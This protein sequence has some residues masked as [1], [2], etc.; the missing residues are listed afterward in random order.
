MSVIKRGFLYITRKR[1]RSILLLVIMFVAAVLAMLGLAVKSSADK[2]ADAVRKSLGSSFAINQNEDM[3]SDKAHV[4]STDL[5]SQ[6]LK[7]DHITGYYADMVA[8]MI[9]VDAQLSPGQAA[10]IYKG[11]QE[12]PEYYSNPNIPFNLDQITT[13]MHIPEMC[14]C[15]NSALH[16]F[17]R[18][19]AFTLVQG[20]HIQDGD[21]NKAVISTDVAKRNNL[22]VG[23]TITLENRE[24]YCVSPLSDDYKKIV[25]EPIKLDIVGLFDVN[26][27][28]E[29]SFIGDKNGS[30]AILT[31]EPEIAENMIFSDLATGIQAKNIVQTYQKDN[32]LEERRDSRLGLNSATFFVDDPANL[33]AAIAEVKAIQEIDWNFFAIKADDSTYKTAVRPLTQLGAVSVVLIA[34]AVVSCVAVLGLTLNMWTKSRR[35]EMGILM[36]LG[37]AKRK[38]VLQQLYESLTLAVVA[39]ILA[40]AVSAA[41]AG[42]VG[43]VANRLASPRETG[44]AYDIEIVNFDIVIDK[45]SADP[46]N[47][48]YGLT[49]Q[50]I[51]I[52]AVAVLGSTALSVGITA[53]NITKMKPKAVL[54]AM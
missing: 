25:G 7:L 41:L 38:L 20:R 16:E 14:Y 4:I 33:E 42:P 28:Q 8:P 51:L 24:A 6:I 35:R 31:P 27:S 9:Y 3:P 12:H 29:L 54:R 49:A 10:D 43:S 44:S 22:S 23:D 11:Y 37:V 45:V 2:Q 50:N 53:R 40:A 34:I 48:T 46:V 47:L 39:L 26:F 5:T 15:N 30:Y 17:F 32:G 19:G 1:G 52:A 36:S 21:V 18:N 13:G